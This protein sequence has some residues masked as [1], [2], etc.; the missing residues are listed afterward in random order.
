MQRHTGGNLL[1]ISPERVV[2]PY[3]FVG[4]PPPLVCTGYPLGRYTKRAQRR[5]KGPA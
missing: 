4:V 3:P 2:A 5:Y 1:Q